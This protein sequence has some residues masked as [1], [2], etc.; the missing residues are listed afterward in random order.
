MQ[1]LYL[2]FLVAIMNS[3]KKYK[4]NK[5][6]EFY[7]TLKIMADNGVVLDKFATLATDSFSF[8]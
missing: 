8:T 3:L 4:K 1:K 6:S 7:N 5:N 2:L